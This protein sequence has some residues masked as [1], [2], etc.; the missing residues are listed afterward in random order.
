MPAEPAP[1]AK[2]SLYNTCTVKNYFLYIFGGGG[3]GGAITSVEGIF[4]VLDITGAGGNGGAGGG[5][6]G[7]GKHFSAI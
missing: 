1:V 5:G 2:V 3:G 4:C 6:G 7:S